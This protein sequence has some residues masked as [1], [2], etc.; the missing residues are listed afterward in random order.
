MRSSMTGLGT[1][2]AKDSRTSSTVLV[3]IGWKRAPGLANWAAAAK[4]TSVAR[5]FLFGLVMDGAEAQDF[6]FP[7]AVRRNHDGFVANF[8][9]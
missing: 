5:L 3:V 1:G 4:P 9:I 7:L 8:L 6:Q 2:L